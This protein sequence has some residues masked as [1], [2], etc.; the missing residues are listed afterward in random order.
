MRS[1]ADSAAT[2]LDH[3]IDDL[4]DGR[5]WSRRLPGDANQRTHMAQLMEVAVIILRAAERT[6]RVESARRLKL[7]SRIAQHSRPASRLRAIALY[8]LPYLPPLWIR[9]EAC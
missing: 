7:W 3:C 2:L 9:P 4:L 8:R 1:Q 6:P 5:D